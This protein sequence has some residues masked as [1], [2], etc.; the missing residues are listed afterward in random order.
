MRLHFVPSPLFALLGL[1]TLAPNAQ[2]QGYLVTANAVAGANSDTHSGPNS[3]SAQAKYYY[4]NPISPPYSIIVSAS[5]DANGQLGLLTGSVYSYTAESISNLST[6]KSGW[7]DTL[8]ISSSTLAAG[9]PVSLA[10]SARYQAQID[11]ELYNP[12]VGGAASA[13]TS[14]NFQSLAADTTTGQTAPLTFATTD[15]LMGYFSVTKQ[16][17][18]DMI[19]HRTLNTTIGAT[20]TLSSSVDMEGGSGAAGFKVHTDASINSYSS[21]FFV[22]AP[23]NVNIV[24]ASGHSYAPT[25]EPSAFLTTLL[26]VVPG[27]CLLCRRL[28]NCTKTVH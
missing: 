9:T 27:A 28:Q 16:K 6:S 1:L 15:S 3:A 17:T 4:E 21:A 2:A 8:M 23:S 12:L 10:L 7:T 19:L 22:N 5:A 20:I 25:P 11:D 14:L 13:V 24:S 26:C 18:Y